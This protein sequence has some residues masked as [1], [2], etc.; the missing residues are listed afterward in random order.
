MPNEDTL[1][2]PSPPEATDAEPSPPQYRVTLADQPK[3]PVLNRAQRRSLRK[4]IRHKAA[5]QMRQVFAKNARKSWMDMARQ[6]NR[7]HRCG[8]WSI[9]APAAYRC[10]CQVEQRRQCRMCGVDC[11]ASSQA[12]RQ[13]NVCLA[14]GAQIEYQR[15]NEEASAAAAQERWYAMREAEIAE[16]C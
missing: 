1:D 16:S 8:L 15:E 13:S 11:M 3:P 7:C 10:Q 14:C 2:P 9:P 4:Y 6:S 5:L 12:W